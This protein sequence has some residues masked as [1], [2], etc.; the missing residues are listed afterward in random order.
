MKKLVPCMCINQIFWSRSL[1]LISA[2]TS[3]DSWSGWKRFLGSRSTSTLFDIFFFKEVPQAPCMKH[4]TYMH[5]GNANQ[6]PTRKTGLPPLCRVGMTNWCC[7]S[8]VRWN[9]TS[10]PK[11]WHVTKIGFVEDCWEVCQQNNISRGSFLSTWRISSWVN[12][13]DW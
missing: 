11:K 12:P 3:R 7:F 4:F 6:K 5:L 1:Q 2:A 13:R 10:V 8:G 9:H